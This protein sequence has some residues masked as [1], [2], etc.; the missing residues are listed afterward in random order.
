LQFSTWPHTK[1]VLITAGTILTALWLITGITSVACAKAAT[2]IGSDTTPLP[3]ASWSDYDNPSLGLSFRYPSDWKILVDDPITSGVQ[4]DG[5]SLRVVLIA[6]PMTSQ[7]VADY[8]A[9]LQRTGFREKSSVPVSKDSW[10]GLRLEGTSKSLEF[11]IEQVFFL[12][13]S[14]FSLLALNVA[15]EL[16]TAN[17]QTIGML[18]DSLKIETD[19]FVLPSNLE[20]DQDFAIFASPQSE[21]SFRYPRRWLVGSLGETLFTISDPEDSQSFIVSITIGRDP[22]KIGEALELVQVAYKNV[23]VEQRTPTV[24][25]GASQATLLEGSLEFNDGAEGI[26]LVVTAVARGNYYELTAIIEETQEGRL[27]PLVE[28]LIGSFALTTN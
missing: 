10:R 12:V 21:F 16:T 22:G 27:R 28:E 19:N 15:G 26:F 1:S 6:N 8:A 18:W 25:K 3:A 4:I 14:G 13:K 23:R 7:T 20:D 2:E 11:E 5:D 24:V 17:R 9:Q